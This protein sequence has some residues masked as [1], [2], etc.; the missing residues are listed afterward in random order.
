[1]SGARDDL[2]AAL[3]PESGERNDPVGRVQRGMARRLPKRF[4]K[5]VT[6]GE[7]AVGVSLL[8]DGRPARTPGGNFLRLPSHAAADLV[9]AEWS[10][11]V[12]VVD[13]AKMPATRIANSALDGVARDMA[14]VQADIVKYAGSDLVCYRADAPAA[15]AAAQAAAWD[16]VLAFARERLGARFVLAQGVVYAA[17]PGGAIAA[18]ARAVAGFDTPIP[19]ACLHVMTTLTGSALLALGHA[20]G[21]FG[22]AEIWAAAHVD[23]DFQ[24]RA[25]GGDAE[26][27]TRRENRWR[28]MRAASELFWS[29]KE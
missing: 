3:V 19:L 29:L 17:Q 6:V 8:L 2:M 1:M 18:I 7:A 20:L 26:A 5:N 27:E 28:D 4:Y 14:S 12:A 15:L 23:E 11:N 25:W 21:R 13:P 22:A 16:P 10:S 24:I 9:A